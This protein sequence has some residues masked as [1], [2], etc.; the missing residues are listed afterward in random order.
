MDHL[1]PH[2][3]Q[4]DNHHIKVTT[5]LPNTRKPNKEKNAVT[6]SQTNKNTSIHVRAKHQTSTPPEEQRTTP[7]SPKRNERK[8]LINT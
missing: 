7:T 2:Q 1:C 3:Q 4:F 6:C 8:P 5:F